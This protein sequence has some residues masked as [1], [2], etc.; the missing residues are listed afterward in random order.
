MEKITEDYAEEGVSEGEDFF[1]AWLDKRFAKN[2]DSE[3]GEEKG[4]IIMGE[5]KSIS[6]ETSEE[7]RVKWVK[8]AMQRLESL[9]ED[10]AQRKKILNACGCLLTGPIFNQLTEK[11]KETRDIDK[12]LKLNHEIIVHLHE[13]A[14]KEGFWNVDAQTLEEVRKDP[15]IEAGVRKGNK[16]YIRKVP[17]SSK[18]Y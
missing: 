5:H 15:I 1:R 14:H 16:I 12:V 4:K 10:Q 6:K 17:G 2:L 11:Y 8:G 7:E 3:V 9:V 13:R 18:E